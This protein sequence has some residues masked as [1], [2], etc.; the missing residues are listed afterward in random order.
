MPDNCGGGVQIEY[1]GPG[2]LP[3]MTDNHRIMELRPRVRNLVS[4]GVANGLQ[5]LA[6]TP[7][8]SVGFKP[9]QT[10]K[11]AAFHSSTHDLRYW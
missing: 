11:Q 10:R 1:Q 8:G 3:Y 2:A 6:G 9:S 7:A 5:A 4:E